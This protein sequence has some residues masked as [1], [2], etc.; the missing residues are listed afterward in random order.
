MAQQMHVRNILSPENAFGG[1]KTVSLYGSRQKEAA[2]WFQAGQRSASMPYRP[3]PAHFEHCTRQ[4]IDLAAL[5]EY[6]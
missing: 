4:D 6:S 5:G 3:I 1:N 2:V